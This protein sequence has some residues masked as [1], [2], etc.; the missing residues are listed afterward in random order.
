M[1]NS[2][3]LKKFT[4]FVVGLL[5]AFSAAAQSISVSGLNSATYTANQGWFNVGNGVSI[6]GLSAYDGGYLQFDI[7]SPSA[8]AGDQFRINSAANP[9]VLNAISVASGIV[10]KGT[11]SGIDA[12]GTVDATLNGTGS[13]ALRINFSSA[14]TNPSFEDPNLSGWTAM[15]QY[16]NLG[17]T[18]IAGY[19]S[20]NDGTYP[21]NAGDDNAA[22]MF[23][24]F[25][26][27]QTTATFSVGTSSLQLYSNMTTATGCDVVHGPAVYSSDFQATAGDVLY[28]DWKAEGGGDNFDVFGY[29]LNTANGSTITVLD[30]TQL[31]YGNTAWTT[32]NVTIPSNGTYKFV[33][34]NGTY[35]AT[36]GMAAGASLFIDNVRVFGNKVNS[37]VITNLA[38]TIEY[39]HACGTSTT[40]ARNLNLTVS[41]GGQTSSNNNAT[42]TLALPAAPTIVAQAGITTTTDAGTMASCTATN[43]SLGTPTTTGACTPTVTSNAPSSYP[44]GNT[45][46]TWTISDS[47]GRTAT[48]QQIVTVSPLAVPVVAA[49]ANVTV[50]T[51]VNSCVA[52]SVSLGQPSITGSCYTLTNNALSSYPIGNTTVTW[53]MVHNGGTTTATQT[54]TV[55]DANLPWVDLAATNS[56]STNTPAIVLDPAAISGATQNISGAQIVVSANFQSGDVLDVQAAGVPGGVTKSYNTGTGVLTVTGSMT[57]AQFQTLLRNIT[58]RTTSVVSNAPRTI[59][60]TAGQSIALNGH[61]YEYVAG[62]LTWT[63]AKA[64]AA[65]RTLNGLQGYLATIGSQTENDFVKSKLG[66]DAWIGASDAFGDI[67]T[68]SGYT[69]YANQTAAEGNWHWVTGPEA[70]ELFSV[71]NLSPVT[72]S[73]KYANWN[74][75]EPNNAGN[76]E[77]YCQLFSTGGANGRWNDLPNTATLGYVVEYGG[78]SNDQTCLVFSDNMV[79]TVQTLPIVST[80]S[81]SNTES[82]TSSLDGNVTNQGGSTVTDRGVAYAT[83]SSPTVSGTKAQAGTGTGTFTANL[84]GLA[85]NTLYYARAYATNAQGTAYGSEVT[86]TTAPAVPAAIT[87]DRNDPTFGGAIICSGMNATL[88]SSVGVGTLEWFSGSCGGTSIGTGTSVTVS[89]TA[90]TTYF[91]RSLNSTTGLRST[92]QQVTVT[93]QSAAPTIAYSTSYYLYYSAEAITSNSVTVSGS[94]AQ[95]Y[96]ASYA[97][98]PALPAGLNLNTATGQI[99]GTATNGNPRTTY[100][101]TG[102][103]PCGPVTT[104]LEIEV[105]QC[106][107]LNVSDFLLRGNSVT[108]GSGASTEFRLTDAVGGQFGAVWN[109]T[110]LDLT[111]DFDISSQVYLGNNN[112]G[113]D[114]IAFV[115]QPL[116]TNQGST[117]GGLGYAGISPSLAVEFDTWTNTEPTPSDHIAMMINGNTNDHTFAGHYAVEME[118]G[119]WRTARFKWEAAAK[120]FTVFLNGTQIL[121]KANYDIVANI[122]NNNANV[123]WGFTGATGGAVNVQKVKFDRYCLTLAANTVANVTTTTPIGTRTSTSAAIAGEVVS[124]GGTEVTERGFVLNTAAAPTTANVKITDGTGVGPTSGTFTGLQPATLYYARAYAINSTGTVYGNEISF[125]TRPAD[126][127]GI[128]SSNFNTTHQ[129]NV[130]CYN[131]STTLTAAGVSGVVYWYSGSCGGTQEGIG[132][133]LTV[134]PTVTTTYYARNFNNS[135]FADGCP[136]ITVVVRPPLVAPVITG[137]EIICWN[138]LATGLA[139]TRATGGSSA[140]TN[141]TTPGFSY[142]WQKS[143]D[144]GQTWQN[145]T[146]QTNFASLLPGYLLQTTQYRLLATDLGSPSCTTNI[147]SNTIQVTV[148]DPF[149]P[150][151]VSTTNPNRTVC[152]GGTLNLTATNTLGGSGPPFQYQW[153]ESNDSL[154]WANVGPAQVNNTTLALPNVTADKHYRIIAFDQG[155]PGC[156]SVFSLNT[157]K[158]FVQAAVT[159]GAVSGA[160]NIC[161][162]TAPTASIA[163]TT[164]GTGRGTITYR[165]EQSTNGGNTWTAVAGATGASLQPGVLTTTTDYRR[166]TIS[167]FRS[168]VCESPSPSNVIRITVDQL[169]VATIVS[170]GI[171]SCVNTPVTVPGITIQHGTP[172]WTHNGQGTISGPATAPVYTPAAADAGNTVVLTLTVTGSAIC[173]N[174]TAT[175]TYSIVVNRLPVATAGGSATIC[176]N[177]NHT[178]L[179]ASAANGT[180]LWTH[181][182]TGS[183]TNAT[184]VAPTYL[185]AAGDAGN[186]V[187]LTMTVSSNNTC[188]PATATATYTVNVDRLPAATAGGSTTICH[189]GTTTVSGATSA[190]GTILWTHNGTGSLTNATTTTPSYTAGAGDAGNTVTLTMTVTSN[191]TCNPQTATATYTVVVRPIFVP[192]TFVGQNQDLCYNTAASAITAAPATGGTGPYAYQWQSSSNGTTWT[193]VNGATTLSHTPTGTL[194]ST[195]YYRILSTDLGSPNCGTTLPSAA[196]VTILVRNPLTP[197]V[198]VSPV[199]I[200]NS[201]TTTLTPTAALGGR[202]NFTY[203]WQQ[204]ANGSTGWTTVAASSTTMPY[205]T[206]SLSGSTYYRVIARDE[207][208][209]SGGTTYISCGSTFSQPTNVVVAAPTTAGTIVG[210][211]TTCVGGATTTITSGTAGT[212]SGTVSYRWEQSANNGVTW[213]AITGANS[214]TY[215][216]GVLTQTRQYRRVTVVTYQGITC[217]SQPTAAV[218]KTVHQ[219]PVYTATSNNLNANTAIGLPTATVTYSVTATAAT[220]VTLTYSFSGATSGSGSGTGSGSAFNIGTTTV[221]IAATTNCGATNTSFTVTVVDNQLPTIT[222]GSNQTFSTLAGAT[223]CSRP[224]TLTSPVATDNA[225]GVQIAYVLTGATT[226]TGTSINNVS[227]NV[228]TT[229]VTWRATDA[230]GNFATTVQLV[231]VVDATVPTMTNLPANISVNAV[232]GTCAA[233]VT[234][235]VPTATD[236][237]GIMSLIP[238]TA[239]GSSFPLGVTTITYTARDNNNNTT[240]GSFTVTVVDNQKPIIAGMPSNITVVSGATTCGTT[241]SWTAPTATDNC[242]MTSFT[243][244]AAPATF[245]GVG[246]T[247]VRYTA[248]DVNGNSDTAGF[249]VLVVDRDPIIT[250][251]PTNITVAASSG[252]CTAPVTWTVPTVTDN[253]SGT[254]FVSNHNPGALF[255]VGTTVVTYTATDISGRTA[256]ATFTITVTD[257]QGPVWTNVPSNIVVPTAS[258]TCDAVVTWSVPIAADNC[259]AQPVVTSNRAPGTVFALGTTAVVYTSVDAAG[260][261]SQATFT[262]T[263]VDQTA[264]VIATPVAIT[265]P[266]D[267]NACV[268]SSVGVVAPVVTDQCNTLTATGVRSD[269]Q[270]LSAA[271]PLGTT[272]ISWTASDLSGNVAVAKT[273][274]VTVVDTVAPKVTS[275]LDSLLYVPSNACI[276]YWENWRADVVATDNCGGAVTLASA[277]PQNLFLNKGVHF[278]NFTLT[279]ANGLSRVYN[280]RIRVVDTIRPK[281]TNMPSNITAYAAAN[282]QASVTWVNPTPSDN[283]VDFVMTSSHSSGDIFPLGTTAVNFVVTDQ[284]GLSVSRSFNITVLDTAKPVISSAPV[285]LPLNAQGQATLS[286]TQMPT[287]TDNCGIASLNLSKTVFNCADLGANAVV[288]TATDVNGNSRTRSVVVNVVDLQA[289][290]VAAQPA[291]LYLNAQGTANL[292]VAAVNNGTT[293]NCSTPV[294]SLS[295]VLF[296]CSNVGANNVVLTATDAAGNTAAATAVVTVLDTIKPQVVVPTAP[297]V[298]YA[299]A[300]TCSPVVNFTANVGA[301]D[302]CSSASLVLNPASGTAFNVGNT[303]VVATATD[304]SGNVR[305]KTFV[306]QVVDTVKPVVP[307]Q[308]ITLNLNAQGQATLSAAQMTGIA[309]NCGLASTVLSKTQFVCADKG[310]NSVLV[311]VTDVNGNSRLRPVSVTVVDNTAPAVASK[312]ATLYLGALGTANLTVAAVN[313]GTTDNCGT[314]VLTLSK[315]TFNCS[316]VGANTVVLTATDA[317]GNAATANALVTVLDTVKPQLTLPNDTAIAY[318]QGN[319]CNRVVTLTGITATD[320][321]S[322]TVTYNPANGSVFN[323]GSTPVVITA[324]DASGNTRARTVYVIV[325]DTIKPVI[326]GVPVSASIVPNTGACSA[327]VSWSNPAAL[328][329]CSATLTANKINGAVYAVGTHTVTWTAVDASGNTRTATLTFT[330]SDGQAP[331]ITNVPAT[332]VLNA[333]ATQCSVVGTWPAITA[334]DNCGTVTVTTSVASGSV[335]ALGTTVVTVTAVDA[336]GNTTVNTFNVVVQDNVDPVWTAT[337]SNILTGSCSAAV[338][339]ALPTASDNC[340]NATVVQTTGLPSGSVFPIG[341]TTNTFVA[342]DASG[343]SVSYSFTVTVQGSNFTYAPTQNTFC[344]TDAP[345]NLLPAGVTTM[346][347]TGVGVSGTTFSPNAAGVGNYTINFVYVDAL[348]CQTQGSFLMTVLAAPAKP[349]LIR[350]SSITLQVAQTYASYQWRRNGVNIA[351]ATQQT[352]VVTSSGAYDVVVSNGQCTATSE[353]YGF[354][355]N[356]S[357]AELELNEMRVQPNPNNGRFTLLHSLPVGESYTVQIVD[358]VGRVVYAAA[359]EDSR[360]DF[361]LSNLAQGQYKVV[362]RSATNVITKP[363]VIQY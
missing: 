178:V 311:T 188:A 19:T 140:T 2:Y 54:V 301:T 202:N 34:V 101:V 12:I 59:S 345:V 220:P 50:N 253:C 154:V 326:A 159:Q 135:L 128:T 338:T 195:V 183:L 278:I 165:W 198:L 80:G 29:V 10:Y 162:G 32:A 112:A 190:R 296:N 360:V 182:G 176:Q 218:T 131:T 23:A 270:P 124:D 58:F 143:E 99:T 102:T 320:N 353:R 341:V 297:V 20:P 333:T 107:G 71:G 86:F 344:T 158:V 166:F 65:N 41:A 171:T 133:T 145:L 348:G 249:W 288:V 117:G 272:T 241:V 213:T 330:V 355:V 30:Q 359:V 354:G 285:T 164:A 239:P 31:S 111:R 147:A 130:I 227:F 363:I 234:W 351:G 44:I 342:T 169:P 63:Q 256:S 88:T 170:T 167:T 248:T 337:P 67:N 108:L 292:T 92:C 13:R 78:L 216:P 304:A 313:N 321:C 328:D 264:P 51:N 11:G 33:F 93:V 322:A 349:T 268:S 211:Q 331:V 217:E 127:T 122:F 82:T 233:P 186:T 209:V 250:N 139:G 95:S 16:I 43:V 61:Y 266:V 244:T 324:V 356:L 265:K 36:C 26:T 192:A 203:Q 212:G 293:D 138:S 224:V 251:L 109:Q 282:C 96:V 83:T 362:L 314:P 173:L 90:T 8:D 24:N 28:F 48:D 15:N 357:E 121:Q 261:S 235:T 100:T 193:N 257:N 230:S 267:A 283:C 14:F 325:R 310:L 180:I 236:A 318:V 62:T 84:T 17:T 280:H 7:T 291:T 115:L 110:R 85:P 252:L 75:V 70:G 125:Y 361:D 118:D 343:N 129:A 5:L 126:V 9:N 91:V 153:Q 184:T 152:Q 290:A 208:V 4:L 155:T 18:A 27:A 327:T 340:S 207:D 214:A 238:S 334:T 3:T 137:A 346:T 294:L 287:V 219:L 73:G 281:V 279:D 286:L 49:P 276:Y 132:N 197:P 141:A 94:G 106:S 144:F 1:I 134:S 295:K 113:A 191:N 262:V 25:S 229:T 149:T 247:R 273:Q 52:T 156:G 119:A 308:S 317:S 142:Q 303:N 305:V 205:T 174:T 228:G 163:N 196:S 42:I 275:A 335:F 246:R 199:I 347:F 160:Q 53:T 336:A 161:A 300:A 120:T 21:G 221:S 97:I 185:A 242:G 245:F 187:V 175:D 68:A 306:V 206:A 76:S 332:L 352:L 225:P 240:T 284:A 181:N 79:V 274:T 98:N 222:A 103:T 302:N 263:V 226:G 258:G 260:N 200:C 172:A 45:T 201:T 57:P 316:N 358:L 254:L 298:R 315:T 319:Q 6:S 81:V 35:D 87:T 231:T 194:I 350:T 148:R 69:K 40:T 277:S 64:A 37:T 146:G 307:A 55:V 105:L 232:T 39:Q 56:T 168:L 60:V 72:Q 329:N 299:T 150:S 323:V 136:S 46:V 309:D 177:A 74:G 22:P 255:P 204:S 77:H 189:L 66:A 223:T 243:T 114:G 312:P 104:T 38:N 271:Y 269:N 339:F 210:D 259:T 151:V 47:Y 289:P 123:Y 116:S 215:T 89:P 179:G 237:C 157:V